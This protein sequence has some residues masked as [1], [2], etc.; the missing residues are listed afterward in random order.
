MVNMYKGFKMHIDKTNKHKNRLPSS[1]ILPVKELSMEK[2]SDFLM[3][4]QLLRTREGIW[5]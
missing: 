2:W 5:I 1:L 3:L 4:T